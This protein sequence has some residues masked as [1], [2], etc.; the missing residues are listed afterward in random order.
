MKTVAQI[1]AELGVSVQTIYRMLNRVKQ[2]TGESLTEKING[3]AHI[4]DKSEGILKE[5]LT[6]V[7]QKLNNVEQMFN[8]VKQAETE[9]I[10]FLR[11]QNKALQ[12][13]LTKERAHSR[14]QT[15]KLSDLAAQLAELTRNN[16]ILLGAEQSRNNPSLAV[17]DGTAEYPEKPQ[18]GGNFFSRVFGK[19][20]RVL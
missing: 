15:D 5:R 6:G 16:Q 13:E 18:K 9:E 12:E 1:A 3:I 10:V 11:E 4:T 2:E 20:L 19:R 14:E 7:K 8:G 17:A